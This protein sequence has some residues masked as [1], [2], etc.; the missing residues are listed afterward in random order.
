MKKFGILA[1][2]LTISFVMM[3][4]PTLAYHSAA[5]YQ[6]PPISEAGLAAY[7]EYYNER[8]QDKK[9]EKAK[10][11]LEK[12]ASE[13]EYW[14]KGPKAFIAGYELRKVY[15]KCQEADKTFFGSPNE[16]NLTN[17]I[18]SCDA[19][20]NK[21]PKPDVYY[22]TRISLGTGYG[23][24]A[25]FYKDTARGESYTDKALQLLAATAP[26]EGWKPEDWNNFRKE[27]IGRLTQYQGLY[28]L[29][30]TPPDNEGAVKFLTNA[31]AIKEGPAVKDPNTY[32]LRAE[33]TTAIYTKLNAEYNALSDDDKRGDKGKGLLEQIYPVVEKM[34]N[35]YARVVALTEG[36]APYKAIYDDAKSQ[37]EAFV[38]FLNKDGNPDDLYKAF[39]ADVSAADAKI[40]TE[41][42]SSTAPPPVAP[43]TGKGAKAVASGAAGGTAGP[44]SGGDTKAVGA[45]TTAP[46]KKAAPAAKKRK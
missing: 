8:D 29:R 40:K 41:E 35:D 31:A 45:K 22:T 42:S 44:S 32:L 10:A 1:L 6:Q 7:T 2:A 9:Y 37:C 26:P 39:K 34:A 36:Q 15:A 3:S 20:I 5:V 24:L 33:A 23:V 27:N 28:K 14:K 11:F 21:S 46:T 4:T 30:Q 17:F 38:K 16:A 43:P 12:F 19:W 18:A 25:S 13:D